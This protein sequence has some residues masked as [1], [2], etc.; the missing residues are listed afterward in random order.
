MIKEELMKNTHKKVD[1]INYKIDELSEILSSEADDVVKNKMKS[2]ITE[3]EDIRDKIHSK[4]KEINESKG[5]NREKL[6]EMEKNIFT[7]IRSFDNAFKKAGE[8]FKP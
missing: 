1:D 6:T 4:Y 3:L 8:I 2:V 5:D 7:D